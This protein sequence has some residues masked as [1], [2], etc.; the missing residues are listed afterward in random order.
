MPYSIGKNIEERLGG[1]SMTSRGSHL[2]QQGREHGPFRMDGVVIELTREE[3]L[4]LSLVG[5]YRMLE[6]EMVGRK[7]NQESGRTYTN[8]IR[9]IWRRGRSARRWGCR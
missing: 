6:S 7:E 5:V 2:V 3:V 8:D 9:G 1:L 4:D